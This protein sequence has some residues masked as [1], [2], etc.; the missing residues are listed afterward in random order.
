MVFSDILYIVNLIIEAKIIYPVNAI[1]YRIINNLNKKI[2]FIVD[3]LD[4]I[5]TI[6]TDE[7]TNFLSQLYINNDKYTEYTIEDIIKKIIYNVDIYKLLIYIFLN[8]NQTYKRYRNSNYIN[9]IKDMFIN[10]TK[11]KYNISDSKWNGFINDI[12]NNTGNITLLFKNFVSLSFLYLIYKSNS[13]KKYINEYVNINY[14]T[15]H[16]KKNEYF[17]NLYLYNHKSWIINNIKMLINNILKDKEH[18]NI[19][20]IENY[21]NW[22]IYY[23]NTLKIKYY[24]LYLEYNKILI[25]HKNATNDEFEDSD[26][27]Q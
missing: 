1:Q 5:N 16:N 9:I 19:Y 6:N 27:E 2:L 10:P 26:Y 7:N 15:F 20:L 14:N 18:F 11:Y 24:N 22:K 17:Y 3:S 8:C 23:I 12:I 4:N 25:F 13:L 21:E